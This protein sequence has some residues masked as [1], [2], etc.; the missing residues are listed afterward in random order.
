MAA[1][2]SQVLSASRGGGAEVAGF[3]VLNVGVVQFWVWEGVTLFAGVWVNIWQVC[4]MEGVES[5][6]YSRDQLRFLSLVLANLERMSAL[7]LSVIGMCSTRT[8]SKAD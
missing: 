7:T 5:V 8:C 6:C 1:L 2:A 4:V 3:E